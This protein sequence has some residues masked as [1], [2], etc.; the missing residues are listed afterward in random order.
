MRMWLALLGGWSLGVCAA[1][2]PT[3]A[4][5]FQVPGTQVGDVPVDHARSSSECRACHGGYA[6]HAEPHATWAGSLMALGGKDPLFYAQLA[7]ANQDAAE[8]GQFCL[9]CHVPVAVG[10]GHVATADGSALTAIDREGVS[11]H[12]CHSMVDPIYKPG[13]SPPVDAAILGALAEVPAHVGNAMFVLDP[14][15]RRRGPREVAS[16]HATEVSPFHRDSAMCGT[17]HDVGNVATT[18][19]ADGSWR[20]NAL[21]TPADSANPWLQYP[22]ERTYTEWKLSSF[23]QGGVDLGGRFGGNRGPV[24]SSC[25]DCHMP[26]VAERACAWCEQRE[27]LA[28]HSFAGAAVPSLDLIAAHT[29]GDPAVQP[30]HIAAGRAAALSMLL[31]AADLELSMEGG[32]LVSRVINQSGHKLPTGHIEGRRVWLNLRYFDADGVLIAEHGRYDY[33]SAT[34][35]ET[36]TMVHEMLVGLSPDAAAATGHPPGLTGH[37]ALADTIEKDTRI[38]PRGYQQQAFIDGGAPAVGHDYADGEHWYE[39]RR[40]LP[41]GTERI[42]A[43]LYYQTLPRSYIEHLRAANT[44]DHWGDTLHALWLQTGRGAPIVMTS[45]QLAMGDRLHRDGFEQD[46]R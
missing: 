15:D 29:A 5:D 27:D 21:D 37:M 23:A 40:P 34:L 18:R 8:V 17:C 35:D 24:V 41:A 25:Q 19:R 38:P 13:I 12:F 33:A 31:R 10:N 26:T 30:A 32:E 3:T 4:R 2:V 16:P 44:S 9:R 1:T 39:A 6:A 22:L 42:R 36:G 43:T 28:V 7:T 14:Q 45:T 46:P 20:Y 11:C